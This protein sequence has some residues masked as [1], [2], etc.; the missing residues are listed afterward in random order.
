MSQEAIFI[1][2]WKEAMKELI[3]MRF[4]KL[5]KDTVNEYLDK[6][7][8]TQMRNPKARLE[9]NYIG[10]V[11]KTDVLSTIDLIEKNKLVIGGGG[12]LFQPHYNKPNP[13][14]AYIHTLR[15][16]RS[17]YKKEREK[18]QKGTFEWLMQDIFQTNTK[19]KVNALYGV[20]GYFKFIL[21]NIF[22]AEAITNQGRQIICTA[23]ECF[24]S[25]LA[26]NVPFTT[27]SEVYHYINNIHNEYKTL[28]EDKL[29]F[30]PF[31][32]DD[33]RFKVVKRLV[34]KCTFNVPDNLILNLNAIVENLSEDELTLLYF[35]NNLQEINKNPIIIDKLKYIMNNI[36]TLYKPAIKDVKNEEIKQLIEDVWDIYSVFI[37]YDYP[38]FDRIRKGMYTNK[39]R[40]LYVDTDSNFLGLK[41]WVDYIKDEIL[42]EN[43][44][45]KENLENHIFSAVNICT[46]FL[47]RVV[48]AAYKTLCNS[49]NISE[50]YQ[51]ELASKGLELQMKNE[52]YM[53]KI[54]FTQSKKRYISNAVLQEGV[55]LKD[56]G[57]PEIKGFDFKKAS[58]KEFVT[59]YYTKMCLDDIL[60]VDEIKIDEIFGKML[61]LKEDIESSMR[62]GESKYLKQSNVQLIEHYK[63][64]Y[65]IPGI[66][67]IILWNALCP[68]YAM[69][70]PN[71]VDI[72]P[73]K[74]LSDK[75]V[76]EM[77]KNKY[78][79][80]YSKL[81]KNILNNPAYYKKSKSKDSANKP[82]KLMD[83]NVIAKP[84]N[85]DKEL[86]AW[87][88]DL[89]YTEK[90]VN[91]TLSLFYPI[92]QSLGLRMLTTTKNSPHLSNIVD[93]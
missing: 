58:V 66:R 59:D 18:Y 45:K 42:D 8:R 11:A 36:D 71:D 16:L 31:Y 84:K 61:M 1:T 43:S 50:E 93:L 21:F 15:K 7:I 65:S 37:L 40:V 30:E 17:H 76:L 78:P 69:D 79:E 57:Y 29:N 27:E 47:N 41:S 70:L 3:K 39:K 85:Y 51:Q 92:L 22:L 13:I 44:K 87:F 5:D 80:E 90:V 75:K 28:Y 33:I 91:D 46:I 14:T 54:V 62:K 24:E 9:N 73:I 35:K 68:D 60:R 82:P 83:L 26:D 63:M 72:V 19:I 86:P 67:G 52:F 81:E 64:P 10:M 6:I 2:R 32:I 77:F 88:N 89:L 38:I 4:G 20:H 55:L 49:M 34:N 74:N 53:N 25:F 56:G 12:V 48:A 23:A